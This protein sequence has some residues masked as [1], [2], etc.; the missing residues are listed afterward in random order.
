MTPQTLVQML[1]RRTKFQEL[2]LTSPS[3]SS[4]LRYAWETDISPVSIAVSIKDD[5][6]FSHGSAMWIHGLSKDHKN[7]FINSEQSEKPRNSGRLRA[8][9]CFWVGQNA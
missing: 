3:Y 6:F 1:L 4:L 7:I 8:I 5:A 9:H 2:R